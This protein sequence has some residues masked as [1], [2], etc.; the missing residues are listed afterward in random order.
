M[1][2][3]RTA[4]GRSLRFTKMHGAGNDFV[5]VDLRH[6]QPVPDAALCRALAYRNTG[7]GLSLIHI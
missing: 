6:G 3:P 2:L 5:V 7:V 4:G 1:T